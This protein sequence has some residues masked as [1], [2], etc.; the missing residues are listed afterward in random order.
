MQNMVTLHKINGTLVFL[1]V[2]LLSSVPFGVAQPGTLAPPVTPWG[3]A[4]NGQLILQPPLPNT[5][6]LPGT[7]VPQYGSGQQPTQPSWMSWWV[8]YNFINSLTPVQAPLPPSSKPQPTP[9]YTTPIGGSLPTQPGTVIGINIPGT[10]TPDWEAINDAILSFLEVL[11]FDASVS[12]GTN[13]RIDQT[14]GSQL[15]QQPP[16]NANFIYMGLYVPATSCA[17][18]SAALASGKQ[19]VLIPGLSLQTVGDSH[20]PSCPNPTCSGK[21][22]STNAAAQGSC[23][24]KII[25]KNPDGYY[26]TRGTIDDIERVVARIRATPRYSSTISSQHLSI[27]RQI[28]IAA[29]QIP[30]THPLYNSIQGIAS[31]LSALLIPGSGM[32]GCTMMFKLHFGCFCYSSP[33]VRMIPLE[34]KQGNTPPFNRL[35]G[36][37]GGSIGSGPSGTGGITSSQPNPFGGR[38]LAAI[39][40]AFGFT[41][42]APQQPGGFECSGDISGKTC[43]PDNTKCVAPKICSG[44]CTCITPATPT[45]AGSYPACNGPCPAPQTCQTIGTTCQCKGTTTPTKEPEENKD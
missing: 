7:R 35:F 12:V 34:T 29:L 14:T 45:C 30:G 3:V 5:Q 37:T 13:S 32:M 1:L 22:P 23:V 6:T 27:L 9:S 17:S 44:T 38:I 4:A 21:N 15:C 10:S 28:L 39:L 25:S 41:G 20:T 2:L 16:P 43:V 18:L 11:P 26:P 19:P 33:G 8:W 31:Y 42:G 36:R 24:P 40:S